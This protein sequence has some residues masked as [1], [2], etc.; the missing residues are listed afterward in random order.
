MSAASDARRT[1]ILTFLDGRGWT[2]WEPIRAHLGKLGLLTGKRTKG[3][4]VGDLAAL[5]KSGAIERAAVEGMTNGRGE[6]IYSYRR[7]RP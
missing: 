2:Q 4:L 7:V 6:P 3:D 5:V 1:A